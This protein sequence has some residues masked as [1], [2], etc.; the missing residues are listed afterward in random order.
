VEE[1][2]K[3][4]LNS[5]RLP[6]NVN[7]NTQIQF[8]LENKN[9]PLPLN[10][11]DTTVSQ[12]D[13]FLKE[14]KE[15]SIYRFYGVV[16]PVITNPLFNE[17]VE[18]YEDENNE[19][20]TRDILS[21][22]IFEK[23]GWIGFYNDEPNEDALQ[24]NDNES[25]LCDF[26]PFDPGYDRLKM[27]DSDGKQNYLLKILYPF[28]NKDIVLVKNNAGISLKDGIPVIEQFSVEL[29]GREY[30]GFRTPMNHGLSDGDRLSLLNFQDLSS[31]A[32][33][34]LNE[35]NYRVFRT[36]NQD[37]GDK[38]RSFIL[39]INPNDISFTIGISTIKR[40]VRNKPSQY[41]VRQFKSIT[42]DYKD[43]D[44]YPAAYGVTYYNDDVAAF[45]FKTDIDVSGIVD[46]LGRPISE[47]FLGIIKN[48]NDS[49]PTSPNSQFWINAVSGLSS[50]LNTRFWTPISAGYD[51]ENNVEVNYNVRSYGDTNYVPSEYYENIDESNEVFD[52]DIVE[53]N[54][55]D[56]LERTLENVYHRIN[57]VY[58]EYLN[59][60]KPEFDNKKEGY[61]YSPFNVITIREYRNVINPL[62]DIQSIINEFNITNP[63]DINNLLNAYDV[64][65]YARGSN[66]VNGIITGNQIANNVYKWR[67]LMDIGEF[68]ASGDGVDYPFES[69]AHYLYLD[70]RFYF[71]RQDPPCEYRLIS[72]LLVLGVSDTNNSNKTKFIELLKSPT[73]LKY[74]I[75]IPPYSLDSFDEQPQNI[76]PLLDGQII[77]NTNRGTDASILQQVINNVF[78]F[79]F[80]D[81]TGYY[82]WDSTDGIWVPVVF[83]LG[84]GTSNVVDVLN[85]NGVADLN[86]EVTLVDFEGEYQL[87]KRDVAGG[88]V[89]L[90]L[91]Q[92]NQ[93]DDEC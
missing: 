93:L 25:A 61:I 34:N 19:I 83:T 82:R 36:G 48:D 41:Y 6:D 17:N 23:D 66:V 46:N 35:R 87:G 28:N 92:Q 52:G 14:R 44:L 11:I 37:N 62:T 20:K 75:N 63:Q 18:I 74:S 9:K 88:C 58:R 51:L 72:E 29:N 4:L 3:I 60:I 32:T 80:T 67:D 55:N 64:P 54:E 79:A 40:V 30:V 10:D 69:G 68:D 89:D 45:N 1:T 59:S 26:F 22:S 91:L 31:P 84:S 86:V 24:F 7:V 38:F 33:L 12:Y 65:E 70:K 73:Y 76:N 5:V 77:F 57:T 15:S 16:K 85:Y 71:Q 42:V 53:Y 49:D 78:N 90:S 47:L 56:L 21:S 8:G 81:T 39:D 43:Y 27:L 50:T 2:N 13:Q